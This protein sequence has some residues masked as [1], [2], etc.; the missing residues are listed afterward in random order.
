MN[1]FSLDYFTDSID[2]AL[3]DGEIRPAAMPQTNVLN[4]EYALG[5]Y[6]AIIDIMSQLFDYNVIAGIHEK[7]RSTID[8]LTERANT[9]Y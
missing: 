9:I 1:I 2:K 4:A 3:K 8:S 6:H 5:K 7:Y